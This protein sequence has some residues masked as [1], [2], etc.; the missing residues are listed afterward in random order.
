M[1]PMDLSWNLPELLNG[2]KDSKKRRIFL[3]R[4][5]VVPSTSR[6]MAAGTISV[7]LQN[8]WKSCG[9]TIARL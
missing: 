9:I 5:V 6:P 1:D 8:S 3:E 2:T 7:I 4:F